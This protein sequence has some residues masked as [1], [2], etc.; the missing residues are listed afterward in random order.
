MEQKEYVV[1]LKNFDDLDGFY[2]DMENP[3]LSPYT[4]NRVVIRTQHLPS[5]R[6]TNYLLTY[7]EA[8]LLA[9]D[10]RVL[11][12]ELT[13]AEQPG[14]SITPG[15]YT[16]TSNY[17]DKFSILDRPFPHITGQ[18]KNW[19]LLRCTQ[20]V[21]DINWG[22]PTN[23][24]KTGTVT[25]NSTGK[26]VDV[27]IVDGTLDSVHPEFA[28]DSSGFG[29]SRA[30]EYNW[31]QHKQ[32]VEGTGNGTYVYDPISDNPNIQSNNNHGCHV[33][34]IVAGN[35]QGWARDATI[36]NI[37]P[38]GDVNSPLQYIKAFHKNKPINP[39][40]GVRNPTVTN[41]SYGSN[42]TIADIQLIR[43]VN[44]RGKSYSKPA[45]GWTK[46]DL[47]NY[48]IFSDGFSC[49]FPIRNTAL[50]A[51][52]IDLMKEGIIC[53]GS[54]SNFYHKIANPSGD[55]PNDYGNYIVATG[56]NNGTPIY[57]NRGTISATTGMICVSAIDVVAP[58]YLKLFTLPSY[59]DGNELKL[60]YADSGPR[61]D[62]YA[63]GSNI[64]SSVQ[65]VEKENDVNTSLPD[66][67]NGSYHIAKKTG[68]SQASPQ[69]A[70]VIACYM[71]E[72]PAATQ[73]QARDFITATAQT[74]R[75][76]GYQ[77][78]LPNPIYPNLSVDPKNKAYSLEGASN[79]YLYYDGGTGADPSSTPPQ[80]LTLEGLVITSGIKLTN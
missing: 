30:V 23:G 57:Y 37:S 58:N 22:S 35:T 17:W 11:A 36:Y 5:S 63:P 13:I 56:Y 49:Q 60:Y 80:S 45:A 9:N 59:V 38:Y 21:T 64:T 65:T 75:I 31:Y 42:L 19:G 71:Q 2:H 28:V 72:Y 62:I 32:A 24:Y 47:A 55:N 79:R 68:T 50:E 69:V 6:N 74:D 78:P 27:V 41:H 73:Q 48:N 43:T 1:T 44:F 7:D 4:P 33:A 53:I 12:V 8:S 54:A 16:Q 18:S 76:Y 34:G 77:L 15:S 70:G 25:L 20:T 3:G 29:G 66:S 26:N 67:R 46:Q 40:T 52:L 61:V 14:V 51:D 39:N 10:P